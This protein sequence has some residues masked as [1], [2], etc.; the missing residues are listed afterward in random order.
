MKLNAA[1]GPDGVNVAFYGAACPW[2]KMDVHKLVADFYSFGNFPR[3]L[4]ATEIVL[5]P[6]KTHA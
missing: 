6:K 3:P 1:S 5:I 2:I 4:N